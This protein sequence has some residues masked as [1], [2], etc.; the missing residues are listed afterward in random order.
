M[1][2][3]SKLRLEVEQPWGQQ[4]VFYRWAIYSGSNTQTPMKI[5]TG[6]YTSRTEAFAAGKNALAD[7]QIALGIPPDL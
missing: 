4:S 1:S 5:A 2:E 7:M 3:P 6:V